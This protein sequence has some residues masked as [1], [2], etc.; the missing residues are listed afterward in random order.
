[1]HNNV[2]SHV[3]KVKIRYRY[4]NKEVLSYAAYSS[5]YHLDYHLFQYGLVDQHFKIYEEIKK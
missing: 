1:L 2:R 4:F 3:A 5:D